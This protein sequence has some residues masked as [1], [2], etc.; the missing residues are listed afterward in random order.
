M[1]NINIKNGKIDVDPS[2]PIAGRQFRVAAQINN[3]EVLG[4]QSSDCSTRSTTKIPGHKAEVTLEIVDSEGNDVIEPSSKTGCFPIETAG[5]DKVV[6]WTVTVE[7][8]GQYTL[9]VTVDPK[10]GKQ[11][12][13]EDTADKQIEVFK[14]GKVPEDNRNSNGGRNGNGGGAPIFGD[15]NG[16]GNGNGGGAPIFGDS[17]TPNQ[18]LGP[19]ASVAVWVTRNPLQAAA[20]VGALAIAFTFLGN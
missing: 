15:S 1:A 14:P 5:S 8:P 19:G 4:I 9:R 13:Q 18:P 20:G 2:E 12:G 10:R 6:V 3:R 11:T 7:D 17:P 16:G